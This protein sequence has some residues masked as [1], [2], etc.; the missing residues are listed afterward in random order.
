MG[1]RLASSPTGLEETP[2]GLFH[3]TAEYTRGM[4]D[5]EEVQKMDSSFI[6]TY[7]DVPPGPTRSQSTQGRRPLLE[8]LRH[9]HSSVYAR[10]QKRLVLLPGPE[11]YTLRSLW[12][13]RCGEGTMQYESKLQRANGDVRYSNFSEY[14]DASPAPVLDS[15]HEMEEMNFDFTQ[16]NEVFGNFNGFVTEEEVEEGGSSIEE[17]AM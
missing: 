12:K 10:L 8:I 6:P 9:H 16:E 17:A 1:F 4:I 2:D 3:P 11:S 7:E 5:W 15:Y 14:L 13:S